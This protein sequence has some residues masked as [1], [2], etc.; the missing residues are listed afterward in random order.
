[1]F[2]IQCRIPDGTD[3]IGNRRFTNV[4]VISN[5]SE[6]KGFFIKIVPNNNNYNTPVVAEV[7]E[8]VST[9]RPITDFKY[10]KF[11]E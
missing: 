6:A 9:G 1:M 3:L 8:C 2:A 7:C 10:K 5:R 11:T 4:G